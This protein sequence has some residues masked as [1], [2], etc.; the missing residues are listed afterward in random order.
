MACT[1]PQ[2]Y[3][4]LFLQLFVTLKKTG[5]LT[6]P[7]FKHDMSVIMLDGICFNNNYVSICILEFVTILLI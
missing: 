5:L 7:H 3:K 1:V 6:I 2:Y 4:T